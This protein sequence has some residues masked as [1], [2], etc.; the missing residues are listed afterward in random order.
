MARTVATLD[1]I[2]NGRFAWNVVTS[3]SKTAAKAMGKSEAVEHDKRYAM[4]HEYMDLCYACVSEHS[5]PMQC[6]LS[7]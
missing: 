5:L 3:Y 2:T 4:A 1:H 6:R 7:S